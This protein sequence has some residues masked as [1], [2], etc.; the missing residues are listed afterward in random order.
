MIKIHEYLDI[1]GPLLALPFFALH[2]GPKD[3]PYLLL[4]FFILAELVTNITAKCLMLAGPSNIR[5]Y[6]AN[7]FLTFVAAGGWFLHTFK[8]TMP[9]KWQL[10]LKLF[11][12]ISLLLLAFILIFEDTSV[13]NSLSYTF[14]SF[15]ICACCMLF[16]LFSISAYTGGGLSVSFNFQVTTGFFIYYTINFFIFF[17]Y[18]LFTRLVLENFG[19]LWGIHNFILFLSCIIL[20]HAIKQRKV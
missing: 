15:V 12:A 5:V 7:A 18:S 13:L 9:V 17:A 1:A 4:L 16:Y 2:K 19:V 11:F 6:Q 8:K 10:P 14:V 20:A 3:K